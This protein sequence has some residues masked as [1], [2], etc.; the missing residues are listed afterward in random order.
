MPGGAARKEA[1]RH[2][3]LL[4]EIPSLQNALPLHS[5]QSWSLLLV[6]PPSL[7]WVVAQTVWW[8]QQARGCK[9][10]RSHSKPIWQQ[11]PSPLGFSPCSAHNPRGLGKALFTTQQIKSEGREKDEGSGALNLVWGYFVSLK[12]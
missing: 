7:A 8:L 11:P 3:W 2:R 9:P 1:G 6:K 4:D 5:E 12:I 10:G